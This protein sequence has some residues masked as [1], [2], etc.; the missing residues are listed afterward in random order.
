MSF[1]KNLHVITTDALLKAS[2]SSQQNGN[3]RWLRRLPAV[4][5]GVLQLS[6]GFASLTHRT[7][8]AKP[9][10]FFGVSMNDSHFRVSMCKIVNTLDDAPTGKR[11]P[12]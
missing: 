4:P 12:C 5:V 8:Q 1:S 6:N 11:C 9:A 3:G 7:F 10:S 2:T